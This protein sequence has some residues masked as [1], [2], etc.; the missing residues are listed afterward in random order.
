MPVPYS[1]FGVNTSSGM[2]TQLTL[3]CVYPA[4]NHGAGFIHPFHTVTDP[5]GMLC[6]RSRDGAPCLCY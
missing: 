5:H 2:E 3:F 4:P 1:L 6:N